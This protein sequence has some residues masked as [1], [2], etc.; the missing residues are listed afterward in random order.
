[1]N[2]NTHDS[3]NLMNLYSYTCLPLESSRV[4]VSP[5]YSSMNPDVGVPCTVLPKRAIRFRLPIDIEEIERRRQSEGSLGPEDC[6]RLQRHYIDRK[7][8]PGLT[9]AGSNRAT[10]TATGEPLQH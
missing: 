6:R 7:L 4:S 1:M 10:M 8:V 5:E 9:K 3:M 2:D